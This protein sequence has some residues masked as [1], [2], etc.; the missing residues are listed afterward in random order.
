MDIKILVYEK[1]SNDI[2]E[3]IN[4]D[5]YN[6]M[7]VKNVSDMFEAIEKY[8]FNILILNSN[9][10]KSEIRL[11]HSCIALSNSDP[12]IINYLINENTNNHF[13]KTNIGDIYELNCFINKLKKQIEPFKEKDI[14]DIYD[15]KID[16]N[17]NLIIKNANKIYLNKN[18]FRLISYLIINKN[19]IISKY[20]LIC[21]VYQLDFS[22]N[23]DIKFFKSFDVLLSSIRKL[24]VIT[25]E[26]IHK[27]GYRLNF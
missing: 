3:G 12:F 18:Q 13:V 14:I 9:V 1:A 20:E 24:N 27:T 15:I 2:Y 19:I 16:M 8:Y 21:Y 11:L 23:I 26:T 17:N 5:D 22:L 6:I 10:N 4:K 7:F 25:I